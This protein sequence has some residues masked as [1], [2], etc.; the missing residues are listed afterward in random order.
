MTKCVGNADNARNWILAQFASDSFR[1][2]AGI[3]YNAANPK[4]FNRTHANVILALNNAGA[5][6]PEGGGPAF[7]NGA[8]VPGTCT[9]GVAFNHAAGD[10]NA[11]ASGDTI[12]LDQPAYSEIAQNLIVLTYN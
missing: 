4:D 1:R 8:A 12:T 2:S 9:I 10:G 11:W 3:A 5:T 7:V 6:A